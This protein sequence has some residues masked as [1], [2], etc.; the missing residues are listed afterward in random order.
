M[1]LS[2]RP[3]GAD[4]RGVTTRLR[5]LGACGTVTGSR[6]LVDGPDGRLLVDCGLFQGRRELRRRNWEPLPVDPHSIGAAVLTHAHLDHCGYLPVLARDGWGGPVLATAA[7]C[8][9]AALVL[10]DSAHLQE[11]DARYAAGHGLSKHDPPRP[12]YDEDD[13]SRTVRLLT[14]TAFG[15]PAPVPGG[16]VVLRPA[17][18]ILGSSVAELRLAESTVV[19]SGDLGRAVHPLLHPPAPRPGAEVV[20]VESTYGDRRHPP[21]ETD[22]LGEVVTRTV[23]R[24]GSV[25]V[26]AFALDRTE[27]VLSA[28]QRLR[29]AGGIPPVPVFVD[30][31]MAL[32][33]LDVYRRAITE[34]ADDLRP[35]LPPDPFGLDCVHLARTVEESIEL[36]A[37]RQPCVIVSASGM[38]SGGRVVHHLAQLAGDRRNTVVIVGF[39]A[40]GTRGSDLAQGAT[41]VKALGSYVTI[42]CEVEVF[43]GMS[44]HADADDLLEWLRLGPPGAPPPRACYV[45]HG[46]RDAAEHL[47]GRVRSELGWVAV[48]PEDGEIVR[49]G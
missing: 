45:V 37:P 11:E 47:A 30:S 2:V 41:Q 33:A 13:V 6:F 4:H 32:A 12:L 43:E 14:P 23:R 25:L 35:D 9:L 16:E 20:V 38:A 27:V 17:G 31:P 36:N 26:P 40:P 34:R 5:F 3:W 8:D 24:G 18:H 7:T 29:R 1:T 22:R 44:V 39:Q 46:E 21:D 42:R 48:V 49:C 15:A 10:R 28:L 19:F